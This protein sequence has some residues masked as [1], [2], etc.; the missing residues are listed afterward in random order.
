MEAVPALN[1]ARPAKADLLPFEP[2]RSTW[3]GSNHAGMRPVPGFEL[4]LGALMSTPRGVPEARP[5]PRGGMRR[6]G[7]A[8]R[9]LMRFK[10]LMA[11]DGQSVQLARMCGE[12]HYAYER[13][14]SAHASANVDLRRLAL[15]LFQ[16]YHGGAAVGPAAR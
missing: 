16:I 13:I 2:G 1:E 11:A 14:A 3:A 6:L 4:G 12:L 15:E 7:A 8:R 10:S 5:A 9:L